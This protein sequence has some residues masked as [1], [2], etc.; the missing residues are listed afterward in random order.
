MPDYTYR[1]LLGYIDRNIVRLFWQKYCSV[2]L[3]KTVQSSADQNITRLCWQE[4]YQ[5]V[6]K[7]L[8]D[9]HYQSWCRAHWESI[10]RCLLGYINRIITCLNWQTHCQK[11]RQGTLESITQNTARLSYKKFCLKLWPVTWLEVV[12]GHVTRILPWKVAQAQTLLEG[13]TDT[14]ITG[15]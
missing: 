8:L 3:T 9:T 2:M 15:R 12:A 1:M 7:L 11:Y 14:D 4:Y 6:K 5:I 13:T 10:V